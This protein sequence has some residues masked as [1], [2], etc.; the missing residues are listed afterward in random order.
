MP[1][2]DRGTP[3]RLEANP[4]RFARGIQ[5]VYTDEEVDALIAGGG[6]AVPLIPWVATEAELP[7]GVP[8]GTAY[9]VGP[10]PGP[11]QLFV[12]VEAGPPAAPAAAP[13]AADERVDIN[14]ASHAEL[15]GVH[16][17]GDHFASE[18]IALREDTDRPLTL[19]DLTTISGISPSVVDTLRDRIQGAEG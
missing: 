8:V 9:L 6:D 1:A 17:I 5:G 11:Y 10:K 15:T 14:T 12:E 13:A 16:R 3:T 4:V 18:I 2:P 7:S 19:D